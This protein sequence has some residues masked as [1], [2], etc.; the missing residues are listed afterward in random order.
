MG[1]LETKRFYYLFDPTA[2]YAY[3]RI[4]SPSG[5]PIQGKYGVETSGASTTVTATNGTPFDPV[6]VGDLITFLTG[7]PPEDTKTN[8][9][10]ATK[11]SGSEITVDSNVTLSSGTP[12]FFEPFTEGT[13]ATDGWHSVNHFSAI[14]IHYRLE[15]LASTSIDILPEGR[16][17]P[18]SGPV[19]LAAATNLTGAGTGTINIDQVIP[20]LRVGVKSNTDSAGDEITIWVTGELLQAK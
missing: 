17:G 4:G 19:A 7:D 2:T 14:T 10:V 15:T 5:H 11:T 18:G 9:K 1:F 6:K 8:R 12:W 16:G 20:F 3:G 13:A